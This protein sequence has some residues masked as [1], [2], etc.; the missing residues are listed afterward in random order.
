MRVVLQLSMDH[1]LKERLKNIN[2]QTHVPI[3]KIISDVLEKHLHEVEEYYG[4]Q[5][6]LQITGQEAKRR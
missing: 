1:K 4:V 6:Q 2:E 3:S 5:P